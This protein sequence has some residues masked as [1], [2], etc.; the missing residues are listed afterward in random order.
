MFVHSKKWNLRNTYIL[1]YTIPVTCVDTLRNKITI[2][3]LTKEQLWWFCV[4]FTVCWHKLLCISSLHY[5][6]IFDFLRCFQKLII[7]STWYLF[8]NYFARLLLRLI[9]CK[10]CELWILRSFSNEI[11]YCCICICLTLQW[12][13]FISYNQDLNKSFDIS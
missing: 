12:G 9:F 5:L 8:I 10:M 13:P 7:T 2:Q 11:F 1:T 3:S 6:Y 4:F